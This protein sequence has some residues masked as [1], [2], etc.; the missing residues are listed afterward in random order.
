MRAA[1]ADRYGPPEVVQ[2]RDMPRPAAKPG[3][4]LVRVEAAA[5]T[6]ADWRI[7]ASA[8]PGGLWLAGRL[9]MGLSKP[10]NPVLG[11]AFAG[12][13]EEIG[14]GVTEFAVG[15]AVYGFAPTGAHADYLTMPASGAIA[16]TP[17]GLGPED[18]AALPFGAASALEFLRDV[19]DVKPGQN[20]LVFGASG[21]V[22][23]YAVQI[24]K[25]LGADVTAVASGANEGL[26]RSLGADR[27]VDYQTTNPATD[28][29]RYD[30]VLDTAGVTDFKTVKHLLKK[31]GAFVPLNFSLGDTFRALRSKLGAG[32][33]MKIAVSG[34]TRA[35]LD[36]LSEMVDRQEV[37]PVIDQVLPLGAIRQAYARVESRHAAGTVVL[38]LAPGPAAAGAAP[39][40]LA[41]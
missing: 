2:I 16:P 20:I 36:T 24:A 9:M 38:A 10:R 29:A 21:G 6:T 13:I 19:A 35:H 28:T 11:N 7:R 14:A 40:A 25:A 23:S 15:T 33:V 34:D 8:F 22:G 1:V 26:V 5:V 18:A 12:V 17:T 32:P 27:F 41:G 39:S 31:D 30:I 3:E 37:R 4:V